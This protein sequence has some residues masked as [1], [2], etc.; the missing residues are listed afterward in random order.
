MRFVIRTNAREKKGY[1]Q[2]ITAAKKDSYTHSALSCP[3]CGRI[4]TGSS[5]INTETNPCQLP[6][7]LLERIILMSSDEGDIILDPFSGTGTTA[8]AA[9]RLGRNF[10]GFEL[11]D[12]YVEITQNKLLQKKMSSKLGRCWVSFYL[13]KLVTLRDEDWNDI[14]EFFHIPS[15]IEK[16]DLMP[17]VL[18]SNAAI[19]ISS[20]KNE[21]NRKDALQEELTLS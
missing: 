2:K 12:K 6:I 3:M 4:F 7:H 21:N 1:W 19:S 14:K 9:K 10:I 15:Q 8:L 16:I 11:D 5:T 18:K 13:D 17:I 20:E